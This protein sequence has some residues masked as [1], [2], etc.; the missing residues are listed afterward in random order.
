ML[1]DEDIKRIARAVVDELEERRE[2]T[3]VEM[4]NARV[5]HEG[6]RCTHPERWEDT[7]CARCEDPLLRGTR[8]R[9][10]AKG[11]RHEGKEGVVY[12][13]SWYGRPRGLPTYEIVFDGEH[14]RGRYDYE[15]EQ[16]EVVG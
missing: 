11:D 4:A 3:R 7:L 13:W 14:G 8:V 5:V 10:K 2:A 15:A 1:A 12:G 9:I 6:F 16:I